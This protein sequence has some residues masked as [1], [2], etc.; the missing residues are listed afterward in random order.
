MARKDTN[1]GINQRI[2]KILDDI[3]DEAYK[4]ESDYMRDRYTEF[5]LSIY[6]DVKKSTHGQY[7]VVTK[8]IVVYNLYRGKSVVSTCLHELAHHIDAVQ[9][10]R[11]GHQK[12][13]YLAFRRLIYASLDM[14]ITKKNDFDTVDASDSNKIYRMVEEYIPHP[15]EYRLPIKNTIRCKNCYEQRQQ[16]KDNGFRWN[17][18]EQVWERECYDEEADRKLMNE[19]GIEEYSIGQQ[20]MYV[21]AVTYVFAR[22]KTYNVRELLK[23]KG[24]FYNADEKM[25]LKKS[26]SENVTKIIEELQKEKALN[27]IEFGIFQKS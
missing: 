11:T 8:H 12:P 20:N 10:G 14:G 23:A 2:K 6:N 22:G 16:L 24:F 19:L 21:K 15:V 5:T 9:N 1:E 7:Q 17:S 18:I 13:F 25:W 27:G 26:E 4:D 3:I